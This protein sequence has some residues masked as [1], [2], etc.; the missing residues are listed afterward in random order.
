MVEP[1]PRPI[2]KEVFPDEA[3]RK[4][5][6]SESFLRLQETAI[7]SVDESLN[8]SMETVTIDRINTAL[9]EFMV[10]F[11]DL[12]NQIASSTPEGLEAI[13]GG[14]DSQEVMMFQ[15][16][17]ET[18]L[19]D[20]DLTTRDLETLPINE[21]QTKTEIATNNYHQSTEYT[22]QQKG[23]EKTMKSIM[24]WLVRDDGKNITLSL[25]ENEK[26]TTKLPKEK[27]I[28]K[29]LYENL[30][31]FSFLITTVGNIVAIYLVLKKIS[32]SMSGCYQYLPNSSSYQLQG[33]ASSD[34]GT[35]DCHR[36][37][38]QN[39]ALCQCIA[40]IDPTLPQFTAP[41]ADGTGIDP[42]LCNNKDLNKY[43]RQSAV[44]QA[45]RGYCSQGGCQKLAC[46]A[47]YN[48][49]YNFAKY[50]PW[51]LISDIATDAGNIITN[52][53]S[54][55]KKVLI[56]I[57]YMVGILLAIAFAFLMIRWLLQK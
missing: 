42:E 6:T 53:V 34:I 39:P 55:L 26:S 12:V 44:C 23:I 35:E 1:E 56:I 3:I 10:S 28:S 13:G 20:N 15:D 47:S 40:Q 54:S 43:V 49:S 32:E 24:D 57:L 19:K 51:S 36:F 18:T 22:D 8:G 37:Y 29:T 48:V 9:E 45:L 11:A 31:G 5:S 46:D 16:T 50:T 33:G 21:L 30:A 27:S 2:E 4:G 7:R 14:V 17:M 41:R 52:P 38:N 25:E